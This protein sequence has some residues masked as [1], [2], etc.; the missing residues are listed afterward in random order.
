MHL[1][2]SRRAVPWIVRAVPATLLALA[3]LA[4]LAPPRPLPWLSAG[5]ALALA[6]AGA[7]VLAAAWRRSPGASAPTT[8]FV[9]S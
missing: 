4:L 5:L 6:V 7:A 9:G 1:A 2:L 3:A 8:A